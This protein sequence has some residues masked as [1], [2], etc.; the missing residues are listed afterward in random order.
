MDISHELSM[1]RYCR[2]INHIMTHHRQSVA[3]VGAGIAGATVA[4]TLA[5]AGHQVHVFDKARGPGG[6]LATR[7]VEWVDRQGYAATTRL[8]H[9]AL[10]F[11]ASNAAFQTFA[12]LALKAGWLTEWKPR[13]SPGSLPLD[14]GATWYVPVPEMPALC[15]HLLY[16]VPVSL[17][18]AVD[19]LHRGPLGWQLQ[20]GGV[21]HAGSFDAVVVAL[22]PAQAAPLL[23]PHRLDWARH[24]ST[25]LM[26]P[27][28]TLMGI[29]DDPQPE[30]GW[31]LA[32]PPSGPLAWVLRNDTRPGRADVRGQRHWVAHA[33]ASWSRR[34]LEQPAAWV[35]QQMQAAL[36]Q[37]LGRC[38]D[39]QH[40]TVHRWRY[41][42]PQ[43]H[44]TAQAAT[45]WWD[46]THGL[47]V[48][49]DFLGGCGVEGAWLSAQA[50]C[51]ALL[52]SSFDGADTP[53]TQAHAQAAPATAQQVPRRCAA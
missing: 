14:G 43:A 17:S 6:R 8:D 47:G 33:R 30:S 2:T 20:S 45:C 50:L 24:A 36:A 18:F 1:N 27:C 37:C 39:W 34:H 25:A 44:A 23:N 9:G 5:L 49:G 31:D 12:A 38:V 19:G 41:A 48:C 11:T 13:L 10:G 35:Q 26:Q 52:Q 4:H 46:A 7:R 15:R 40:C 29:T 53:A 28:W 3:V 42:L 21:R 51:A 22:P 32:R 16:G